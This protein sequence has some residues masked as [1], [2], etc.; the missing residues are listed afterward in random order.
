MPTSEQEVEE[1]HDANDALRNQIAEARAARSQVQNQASLD[2]KAVALK[3]EQ[4]RLEAELNSELLAI[5][6][7]LENAQVVAEQAD[8]P[9]ET[10]YQKMMRESA[11]ANEAA[12]KAADEKARR[13]GL[14]P[15]ERQ[16]E[17]DAAARATADE[18]AKVAKAEA[19]AAKAAKAE[20]KANGNGQTP[21]T[22]PNT[23]SGDNGN[24][25]Q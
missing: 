7:E 8:A 24:G 12:Q 17:D 25:G 10:A 19:D 15:E 6:S 20:A 3:E 5:G 4:A 2:A 1:L 18:A 13:D 23:G 22:P 9:V 16:A 11:E 14:T 21:P